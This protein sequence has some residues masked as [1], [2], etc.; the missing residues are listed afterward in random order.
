LDRHFNFTYSL[1]TP[2]SSDVAFRHSA[3]G[4]EHSPSHFGRVVGWRA[5]L[6]PIEWGYDFISHPHRLRRSDNLEPR[7]ASGDDARQTDFG[8][9]CVKA[10][11][12]GAFESH[13]GAICATLSASSERQGRRSS[14]GAR[15]RADADLVFWRAAS[16]ALLMRAF[17]SHDRPI[18]ATRSAA[19]SSRPTATNQVERAVRARALVSLLSVRRLS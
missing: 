7:T 19:A 9:R 5:A 13:G 15:R 8:R 11:Q 6:A 14:C 17:D 10:A 3:L 16:L 4:G 18:C 1:S 12:I 2:L